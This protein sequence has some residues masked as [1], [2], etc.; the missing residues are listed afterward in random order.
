M[1]DDHN[2]ASPRTLHDGR[3][4]RL[5]QRGGWEY[6]S[7]ASARNVVGVIAITDE[8]ELVLVEQHRTPVDTAVIELPAGLVG[9]Q[10]AETVLEAAARE[11]EEETGYL[12]D[13]FE[14]LWIGPSSAGLTDELVSLVRA[15]GLRRAH[16]G[17][18]VDDERI[19][20]HRVPLEELD[21][22]LRTRERSGMLVDLKV[23]L[24]WHALEM[25]S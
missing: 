24:V 20:V 21:S 11:L 5:L 2:S 8:G 22:W 25:T 14:P 13:R 7:R 9:D 23:R 3:H 4:L 15:T 17:G 10:G 6:V 16:A 19:I 1:T 12:A 18:G